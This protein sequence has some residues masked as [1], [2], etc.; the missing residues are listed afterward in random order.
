MF[1]IIKIKKLLSVQKVKVISRL[2]KT[3]LYS[4]RAVLIDKSFFSNVHV[5]KK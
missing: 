3:V 1:H 4:I 2:Q 5:P